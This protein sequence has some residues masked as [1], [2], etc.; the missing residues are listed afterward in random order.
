MGFNPLVDTDVDIDDPM[1]ILL[2]WKGL[3]DA[4]VKRIRVDGFDQLE[5]IVI[6]VLED[7]ATDPFLSQPGS[8]SVSSGPKAFWD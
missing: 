1:E 7:Q 5:K 2:E 6:D 4:Q 8:P 3:T